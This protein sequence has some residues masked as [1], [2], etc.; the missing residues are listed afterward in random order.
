M[1]F[2]IRNIKVKKPIIKWGLE[3]L[4]GFFIAVM[5]FMLFTD[6]IPYDFDEYSQYHTL[7]CR[8]YPFNKHN[9]FRESCSNNDL[10]L[11]A[12]HYWPL[13]AFYYAGSLPSWLYF[14]L[15]F[16]WRRASRSEI[17]DISETGED[18]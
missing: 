3:I 17:C 13:R 9:I 18:I 14:P 8:Y 16:I 4:G 15:F 2:L 7:G 5:F 1:N 12:D 6:V 11:I 10:A